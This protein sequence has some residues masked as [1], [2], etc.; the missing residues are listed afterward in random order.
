MF[1]SN[2]T[3][4]MLFC[5]FTKKIIDG[6]PDGMF[7]PEKTISRAAFVKLVTL[8]VFQKVKLSRARRA[9]IFRCSFRKLVCA[10]C[11]HGGRT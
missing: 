6:Y 9:K 5:I 4:E 10:V 1:R 3:F 8:S 11:L 7:R 2:P